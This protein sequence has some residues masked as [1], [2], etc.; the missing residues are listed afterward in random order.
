MTLSQALAEVTLYDKKINKKI[1]LLQPLVPVKANEIP[2]GYES[3]EAFVTKATSD[4]QS[5]KALIS[6]RC[7]LKGAILESNQAT[8]VTMEINGV[9][10]DYTVAEAIVLRETE[11]A[12]YE[13]LRQHLQ[14]GTVAVVR[15]C[16]Q[17]ERQA[18]SKSDEAVKTMLS[19]SENSTETG[20]AIKQIQ[21]QYRLSTVKEPLGI[22]GFL[23]TV[24]LMPQIHDETLKTIDHTLSVSNATTSITI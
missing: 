22:S 12:F 18:E 9:T 4:M 20:E 5:V 7:A 2:R 23:E 21:E 15:E 16:T 13:T 17:S 11:M 24:D 3:R 1:K 8:T 6:E 14:A 10:K 19:G